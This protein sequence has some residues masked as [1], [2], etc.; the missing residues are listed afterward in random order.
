MIEKIIE[1]S[2]KQ[3]ILT[4]IISFI[5]IGIGCWSAMKLPIDA[6]PDVTNV[7]VQINT[8]A[9]GLA[10]L[11]VEKLI[12][13][14]I[15]VT[16][17][18]LPDIEEV[19]S[20]S[21]YGLSQVTVV[22]KD[23][24][25]L[26]FGRQLV[27]ERLQAAKDELP[28]GIGT[29]MMGPIAT[30]LGEIYFYTIEGEK[31]NPIELRTIQDWIVKPQLRTVPGVTEV[32]SIGGYEKQYQVLPD[33]KKLIAHHVSFEDVFNALES[34]NTNVGGSYI[35]HGQE[36]YLVRGIGLVGKIDDIENI[37]VKTEE[38]TPVYVRD[39]AQVSIGPEMRTG[40]ATLNGK[41]TVLGAAF[42][43]K[44]ENSRVVSK[45]VHEKIQEIRKT[46]PE[47]TNI[48]TVYNRTDLV[49][50]TIH[51]VQ[52]N[53]FEGGILVIAV[54]LVLL[55]NF[56]A[57]LIV[58]SAI[59]LSMLFAIT[60]MAATKTSGNLM[61]L[62]AIDFGLIVDGAVV[63]VENIIRRLSERKKAEEVPITSEVYVEEITQAAREVAKP[64]VF[65]ISIITIVYLPILTLQ[66]IEGKMFKPMALT[67][68]MAL[69]A[70]LLLTLTLIPVLCSLILGRHV[71]EKENKIMKYLH[72]SYRSI[73]VKVM[74]QKKKTCLIALAVVVA[75]FC[76]TP[77]M[78]SV[79]IPRLDE[80]SI[81][82]QSIKLPSISL[83]E[84]TKLAGVVE[85]VVMGF[86]EVSHAFT[87]IGTAE[88]ATDPM[89]PEHSDTSIML[90]DKV[91]N[92]EALIERM[93]EAV[94]KVP[95]MALG[96]SQPIELRVNELISGVRSDVAVKIFGDDL[97][98]LRQKAGE[99]QRVLS[100]IRGARDVKS[101][102]ISGFPILN[103]EV[104]RAKIA[105]YG[106]NVA[107]VLGT[108][109]MAF[110]GKT[111]GEV[112]EGVKRFDLV[113]RYPP[114]YRKT[115]ESVGNLLI[116]TAT[117]AKIPVAELA[118][119]IAIEEGPA[120]ISHESSRRRV[121][122]EVNVRG[123]D[124]AGFVAE[125][126]RAIEAKVKLPPGYSLLW[127]GQFENLENARRRLFIVIPICLFL[128]FILLFSA[129]N[130]V[131]Q[132]LLVFTGIPL[133]I[134]GGIIALFLARLPFSISAGVGFI[135]LFGV[136]MLNGIVM[137]SYINDLRKKGL[138]LT[139]A[140]MQGAETRLR[141]VLMTAL[142]A[143]LG[144]VPMALAHG[145]GAEVQKPL[146][147]VVIGGL[148]S[149]TI[150]TLVLLPILYIWF[151]KN[152]AGE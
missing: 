58:A 93:Q 74:A 92:K 144:F 77:F 131:K 36:Q 128:I 102:Q 101:E 66:G 78:G 104:D 38:N 23:H 149:S 25:D 136:A 98:V 62:G 18:G 51:T 2:L 15:E 43:L 34:N 152:K 71:E 83:T 10:P 134:S 9:S 7:Q 21:R 150:L 142:V 59:P 100:S 109:E 87:R 30:G 52:K 68:V 85:K 89:G 44:G 22:F 24:V 32:N 125:A 135:A 140:V 73:L 46:L 70:S 56:R 114:E 147:I 94:S 119:K 123:R 132:A 143:S 97:E 113:L 75:S 1:F 148:V 112:F 80:E 103:V 95:G 19:R 28:E 137:V 81:S 29:P 76:I 108:I 126:K 111:A 90:K 65:G 31:S 69:A 14:P 145:T 50:R 122:I 139:K 6:V 3:R 105:R 27:L 39:I 60:G 64:V 48:K 11:E 63:M 45:R 4:V 146:A 79:F 57:G 41:E 5:M 99:I 96:F 37:V 33:P 26:Y 91:K 130:S 17:N 107:D 121:V 8:T 127:G 61:S 35:E 151:E 16:M 72:H 118:K 129:F 138:N 124:I 117:G 141:P 55:G 12:T 86:P 47:G 88:I 115:P 53:L 49:N 54:L 116:T 120:Q 133:A 84:S 42:M 110:G 67:V 106:L 40:S 82:I 13:Y 20:L